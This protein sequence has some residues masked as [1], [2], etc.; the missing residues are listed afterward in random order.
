MELDCETLATANDGEHL[1]AR[2]AKEGLFIY[3]PASRSRQT[4]MTSVAA[5]E[6]AP[7]AAIF[8]GRLLAIVIDPNVVRLVQMPSGAI[9]AD[10]PKGRSRGAITALRW[11]RS[12][13][14]LAALTEDGRVQLWNLKP[15][16][17]WLATHHLER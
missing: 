4:L 3:N 12:G 17:E 1:V 10:L 5:R 2:N 6:S 11:D 7:L 15:W 16:H 14:R 8:D 9:F 13:A